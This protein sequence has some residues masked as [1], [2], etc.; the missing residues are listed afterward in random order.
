MMTNVAA[1]S[2]CLNIP[3]ANSAS[4]ATSSIFSDLNKEYESK[5]K[6]IEEYYVKTL[7]NDNN[8]NDD[9]STADGHNINEA[10]IL[11]E[12]SPRPSPRLPSKPNCYRSLADFK[13]LIIS[14]SRPLHTSYST[15]PFTT[16]NN[17]STF[18]ATEKKSKKRSLEV[19]INPTYT[20]NA[21][22]LPLTAENL[23][24]LSQVNS[25][26]AGLP[27]VLPIQKTTKLEHLRIAPLELPQLV[28]KTLYKTELCESFTIR[29]YCKYG[30]KCQFAH[31]LNELKF[32]KKSNNYRTK[33]C[34]NWS[35]LGYCPYGKRCCFK[36]GD[37]KDVRIYQSSNNGIPNDTESG[38][39]PI[40]TASANNNSTAYLTKPKNLHTSVKALQRMTW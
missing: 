13:D 2:Y 20:T 31:G 15:N 18:A 34:I 27:Y 8:D 23:Q 19:E 28:N 38:T 9:G 40:V 14:D 1:N 7:L 11:S 26:A 22:S 12:F 5:I 25:Q 35:K 36:H 32:K 33:P 39:H 30:N 4:T 17:I 6:E 10:D 3:N 21:F 16:S 24:K 37:D 29:G